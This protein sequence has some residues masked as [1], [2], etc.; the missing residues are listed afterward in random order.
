VFVE[1]LPHRLVEGLRAHNGARDEQ[2]QIRWTRSCCAEWTPTPSSTSRTARPRCG[3]LSTSR[4][5][6]CR[7]G[8]HWTPTGPV[9]SRCATSAGDSD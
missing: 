1:S 4:C 6:S 3:S 8:R 9:E 7:S 5:G 2:E